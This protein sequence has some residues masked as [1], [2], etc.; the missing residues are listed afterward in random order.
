MPLPEQ[1]SSRPPDW[2][3]DEATDQLPEEE[4]RPTVTE[5]AREIA[6]DREAERHDEYDDPD[7]GG[8]G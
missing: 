4:D 8:E 5:R 7:E 6:E 3:V 2:A 1:P